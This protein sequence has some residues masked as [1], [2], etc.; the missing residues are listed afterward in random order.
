MWPMVTSDCGGYACWN[1]GIIELVKPKYFCRAGLLN[2][3]IM[4]TSCPRA[5]DVFQDACSIPS[6]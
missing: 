4:P 5:S 3:S 6:P 1:G 2:K